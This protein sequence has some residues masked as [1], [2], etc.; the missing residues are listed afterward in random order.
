MAAYPLG[1]LLV[2]AAEVHSPSFESLIRNR[3]LEFF[4]GATELG[5]NLV[6]LLVTTT[7]PAWMPAR[8]YSRLYRFHNWGVELNYKN[9]NPFGL[10]GYSLHYYRPENLSLSP[11]GS[12]E[13]LAARLT[14]P[15]SPRWLFHTT[16]ELPQ[17]AGIL[18]EKCQIE[19]TAFPPKLI[20]VNFFHW[21]DR[22]GNWT[23]F[24]CAPKK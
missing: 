22:F 14:D 6:Y 3:R 17:E 2:L 9:D 21:L 7:S 13:E 18:R 20:A 16:S 11:I 5:V 10:M 8:F 19:F 1:I 12:Y 4:C 23:L 15:D 24:R